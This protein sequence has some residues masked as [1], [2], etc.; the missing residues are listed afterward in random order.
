MKKQIT[1][2]SEALVEI[3]KFFKRHA[4][5]KHVKVQF[6]YDKE[7]AYCLL[8]AIENAPA[9]KN[10]S[11]LQ[12][13]ARRAIITELHRETFYNSIPGFNDDTRTSRKDVLALVEKARLQAIADGQ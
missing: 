12:Y 10:D 3:Q 9:L 8:G 5:A 2:V 6:R 4:W 7:P 1:K 13:Y 11:D